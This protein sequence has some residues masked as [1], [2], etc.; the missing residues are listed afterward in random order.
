MSGGACSSGRLPGGLGKPRS[1]HRPS[2]P[3]SHSSERSVE[4]SAPPLSPGITA[5]LRFSFLKPKGARYQ[6]RNRGVKPAF[7]SV[8]R[9]SPDKY[10]RFLD[11]RA[12][13]R[14][15]F[16][17]AKKSPP[18][19]FPSRRAGARC[20]IERAQA[21]VMYSIAAHRGAPESLS[22]MPCLHA[23]PSHFFAACRWSPTRPAGS[24]RRR[25]APR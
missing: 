17:R 8:R 19:R 15:C 2:H 3:S 18:M 21:T 24:G 5:F 4:A 23:V 22:A 9:G 20:C 11:P 14:Q 13:F 1:V 6:S 7:P 10:R 12:L 25:T 16:L